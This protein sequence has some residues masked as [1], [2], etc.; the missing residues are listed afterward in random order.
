MGKKKKKEEEADVKA[1]GEENVL[2]SHMTKGNSFGRPGRSG[3]LRSA[4]SISHPEC[5][6]RS[7]ITGVKKKKGGV[8]FANLLKGTWQS[9]L[10]ERGGGAV[11][12]SLHARMISSDLLRPAATP[13][14]PKSK[15]NQHARPVFGPRLG[16]GKG[17]K[18]KGRYHL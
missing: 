10:R 4:V 7:K 6:V 13:T 15:S 17:K 1:S 3:R 18:N 5:D 14:F 2:E 12:H 11:N 16:G 9:L 8:S